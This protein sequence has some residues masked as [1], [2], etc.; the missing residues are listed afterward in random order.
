M[1]NRTRIKR[2]TNERAREERKYLKRLPSW[3][4]EHPF[5]KACH[6]IDKHL[7]GQYGAGRPT[8]QCHHKAGRHHSLLNL[9]QYW[10]PVCGPCHDWITS[11]GRAARGLGLS[12]DLPVELGLK[13]R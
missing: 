10:L 1:K 3:L 7:S 11:H 5:C 6:A 4:A 12:I 8:N 9:E 13:T 2:R